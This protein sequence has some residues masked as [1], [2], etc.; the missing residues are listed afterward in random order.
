MSSGEEW[1]VRYLRRKWGCLENKPII[2]D[3]CTYTNPFNNRSLPISHWV[4]DEKRINNL[5]KS[6]HLP[7]RDMLAISTVN[8]FNKDVLKYSRF[9]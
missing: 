9:H 7:V 2:P 4:K 6:A 5:L 3:N 8:F 1:S